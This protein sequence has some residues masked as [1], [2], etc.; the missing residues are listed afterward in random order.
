MQDRETFEE[1]Y[2]YGEKILNEL[3]QASTQRN[4]EL[5]SARERHERLRK[6]LRELLNENATEE[7]TFFEHEF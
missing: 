4:G 7:G 2:H 1:L 5:K 6:N 3:R